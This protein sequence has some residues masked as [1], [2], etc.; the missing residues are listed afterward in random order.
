MCCLQSNLDS[1]AALLLR[2]TDQRS[3]FMLQQGN[4]RE[5][6]IEEELESSIKW[7]RQFV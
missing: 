6:V 2:G 7:Q 3:T 5:Q 1:D 4:V